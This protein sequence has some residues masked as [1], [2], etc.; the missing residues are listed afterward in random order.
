M[1]ITLLTTRVWCASQLP[2]SP[3]PPPRPSPQLSPQQSQQ[4]QLPQVRESV[5]SQD[6]G[7][8]QTKVDVLYHGY[9]CPYG[10]GAYIWVPVG[11]TGAKS[12]GHGGRRPA[13]HAEAKSS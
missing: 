1:G 4:Q 13:T 12:D 9:L 7:S 6:T 10:C 2:P 8:K 5:R 3:H 11:P